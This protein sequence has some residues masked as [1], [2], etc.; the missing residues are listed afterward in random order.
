M[1]TVIYLVKFFTIEGGIHMKK[2][3][4]SVLLAALTVCTMVPLSAVQAFAA[5]T[6]FA[7]GDDEEVI[8]EPENPSDNPELILGETNNIVFKNGNYN[9]EYLIKPTV[10]AAYKLYSDAEVSFGGDLYYNST[11][12]WISSKGYDYSHNFSRSYLFEAGR[13]Y[14]LNLYYYNGFPDDGSDIEFE[15]NTELIPFADTLSISNGDSYEGYRGESFYIDYELSP[16]TAFQEDVQFKSSNEDAVW[17]NSNG[18]VELNAPGTAVITASTV[19]GLSETITVTVLEETVINVGETK[20]VSLSGG[21][22][23][24]F[25]FTA[26]ET[27]S[28]AFYSTGD[29]D[30]YGQIYDSLVSGLASDD[31]SGENG[32][33]R[34]V[35]KMSQG[36]TYY[37]DA[38]LYYSSDSGEFDVAVEA[39][40][41][42]E[43]L[44]INNG[45]KLTKYITDSF[46]LN[47]SLLPEGSSE[48]NITYS[49]D[50]SD[51]VS[52][53]DYNSYARCR[54]AGTATIT[55]TSER[56]LT[57]T[58]EVTVK[59]FEPLTLDTPATANIT[60]E[61]DHVMFKFT[62]PEEGYYDIKSTGAQDETYAR[63]GE[64]SYDSFYS[65]TS[66]YGG[67]DNNFSIRYHL[68]QNREYILSA[69]L[70][71][72]SVTGSF[73]V[74]LSKVPNAEAIAIDLGSEISETK[75]NSFNLKVVYTPENALE[76]NITWESSDESVV[77]VSYSGRIELLKEGDA[78]VTATTESGLSASI[79][80]HVTGYESIS[81]GET[82]TI[83]IENSGNAA[84][85]KF[86][87]DETCYYSVY[88]TS[89]S[90]TVGEILD[91]NM[92]SVYYNDDGGEGRN[93]LICEQLEEGKT[94][95]IKAGFYSSSTGEF[96]LSVVKHPNATAISFEQSAIEG[97][98]NEN[99]QL[100][101]LVEPEDGYYGNLTWSTSDE[102][103]ASVYGGSVYFNKVGTAEITAETDSG[104]KATCSV[105]VLDYESIELDE[106]KQV[107]VNNGSSVMYKFV[108]EETADYNFYSTGDY[109]TRGWIY[110]SYMN[111]LT[112]SAWGGEGNNFKLN[113]HLTAG[114]TY[115][116]KTSLDYSDDNA[117]Y[118]VTVEMAPLAT[119]MSV[120]KGNF[121]A[122]P[123]GSGYLNIQ[124][125][126][127]DASSESVTWSSSDDEIV[128]VNSNGGMT[129]NSV[130]TAVITATSERGLTD[131][132]TITVTEPVEINAGDTK[133]V[134]VENPDDRVIFKF[135]P[136]Q[137]GE[138]AFYSEGNTRN[139]R[140]RVFDSDYYYNYSQSGDRINMQRS[141]NE[142]ETYYFECGFTNEE[143]TGSYDVTLTYCPPAEEVVINAGKA[144]EGYPGTS[145]SPVV[146]FL[147]EHSVREAYELSSADTEIA[148]VN[149]YG[150][151]FLNSVGTT[152]ITL[153]SENGLTATVEVTVKDYDPLAIGETKTAVVE[154]SSGHMFK[155]IP[156]K[157]GY[158]AFWSTSNEDTYGTLYDSE[159][160]EINEDDDGGENN[161]F[162]VKAM[163]EGG[164]TYY[165]RARYLSSTRTGSFAVTSAEV[166]YITSLTLVSP[167]DQTTYV[168]G[169]TSGFDYTGLKLQAVWSDGEVVN[170]EYGDGRIRDEY[171]SYFFD[172]G[173]ETVTALCGGQSV[174]FDVSV[175][176][177][178]VESIEI[179]KGIEE[180]LIEGV[181][182]HTTT[183]Y[184]PETGKNDLEFFEY[185]LPDTSDVEVKVNYT[186]GTSGIIK[187]GESLYGCKLIF[188]DDQ[189]SKPWT[190]GSDNEIT[191]NLLGA[192]A[193]LYVTVAE[194]PVDYIE[195]IDDGDIEVVENGKGNWDT[196]YNRETGEDEEFFRYDLSLGS[197]EV[198]IHFKDGTLENAEPGDRINGYSV[199][200]S[201][202][203]YNKPFKL[204]SDN[205]V[206]VYYMGNFVEVPITVVENPVE[207]VELVSNST[208]KLIENGDGRWETRYDSALGSD[209]DFFYYNLY[210]LN[211]A[212]VRI[213][214]KDGTSE[215]AEQGEYVRGYYV[216][217]NGNQYS[218][219][220]TL[221]NNTYKIS[222]LGVE[223]DAI[224][225]VVQNPVKSIQLL[226]GFKFYRTEDV[227]GYRTNRYDD[228]LGISVDF[229]Y[230]YTSGIDKAEI[231]INYKDGT[232]EIA[233][234]YDYID[235]KQVEVSYN[236]YDKPWTT[237][238][239]NYITV[240]YLG[241]ETMIPVIINKNPV[242]GIEVIKASDT[243]LIENS[244]G[245]W[246]TRYNPET[247]EYDIEYFQYYTDDLRDAAIRINYTDGTQKTAYIGES[248]D[249]YYIG[250]ESEQYNTP[251]TVGS[252]NIVYITYMGK[253]T[254]MNVTVV[255][256][257]VKSI[258]I[259]SAPTR[260]YIYGDS[261]YG[262]A[263]YFYPSDLT[264]LKFTVTYK[265]GSKKTYTDND[266]SEGKIDGGR[267][268]IS[269]DNVQKVGTMVAT[270]TY[271]GFN[272][273]YNIT[274]KD[275][276]VGSVEFVKLPTN[277]YLS[278]YYRVDWRGSEIKVNYTN[279]TS[280]TLT[281]DDSNLI[282]GFGN[283]TGFFVGFELD[284]ATGVLTS[285]REDENLYRA[286]VNY[287]GK[288]G[289]KNGL[290]YR[291]DK[292]VADVQIEN[293][294]YE[295]DGM[296]LKVT[297]EDG[298]K[299]NITLDN[300]VDNR[301]YWNPDVNYVRALTD[302][303]MLNFEIANPEYRDALEYDV[304]VFNKPVSLDKEYI[305]GDADGNG[306]VDV[307]DATLIQ[308]YIAQFRVSNTSQILSCGDVNGDGIISV[309]DVTW[310]QRYVAGMTVPYAIGEK[311]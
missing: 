266:I 119:A 245:Y 295:A 251:W 282:Y 265:D 182:G 104:L 64:Y 309:S 168:E 155:I 249:G 21:K 32:N 136:A 28:Y 10:T 206:K 293:F 61:L 78:E 42:A 12:D 129:F 306:V 177:N 33:F 201:E 3:L 7:L 209:V 288:T 49:T 17:V 283:Q 214:F 122:V 102:D 87:P 304:Y 143:T 125:Y 287:A 165:L 15:M 164:K 292:T 217:A 276:G 13:E 91:E 107:E 247:G 218:E 30:T 158:Y 196:Y 57:D 223:V 138:Y 47:S 221:G 11:G 124:F 180:P 84:Y 63:L 140:L 279:G 228:V 118:S 82:K 227:D 237:D 169:F 52:I 76:E 254:E 205:Y 31:S 148:E 114:E 220:F 167:P 79:L 199:Y 311:I 275:S 111:Q 37:L 233:H 135:T 147:P 4:L 178:P 66:A 150:T 213:N 183:R 22:S 197:V 307:N 62:V 187:A 274:V 171:V 131:S 272:A 258:T 262:G 48:E 257:P 291:E 44:V 127:G 154:S 192:E 75:N 92:N 88:T 141:L 302:K 281:L 162:R 263:N 5:Q 252:D 222:Y 74:V 59:D 23:A 264:G 58:L 186:D 19:S 212:V 310:I 238:G 45:D 86:V 207:S 112:S 24:R 248:V 173:E 301:I 139:C 152:T 259:D 234:P 16:E 43:Q 166:P 204:G 305:L 159:M 116:F 230:Y 18:R 142:G 40:P 175:I 83:N 51:V 132:K 134:T 1:I 226:G 273:D 188:S 145:L 68:Y 137:D 60:S 105:T 242:A 146:T 174:S 215:I 208:A 97:Y 255:E 99:K 133:T 299:E 194:N 269:C 236:Q 216:E 270:L 56:G 240:S 235:D 14:R 20:T 117:E 184:N 123:G 246:N 294:S 289:Q 243:Q 308:R 100:T 163:L 202:D 219:P 85:Y 300:V 106:V 29:Y 113:Y 50:N 38:K 144:I 156:E 67:D 290:I 224:A 181:N 189:Y 267:F 77:S 280:K 185:E 46:N 176:E 35:Y 296:I 200:W 65:Y 121:I 94:Y 191:V 286:T 90:D 157:D 285:S 72:S 53:D 250:T 73:N 128:S 298:S 36:A 151:I 271:K 25:A 81:A 108:P 160:G 120:Y 210:R 256:T 161:N 172:S 239:E 70:N 39:L 284:G 69:A 9:A 268:V 109:N 203:Q 26:P 195:L 261:L 89:D 277:V 96:D 149:S 231:Q 8:V 170:W 241:A 278:K 232:S 98:P 93:F 41:F 225:T 71:N 190:V 211:D 27:R 198:A 303:G 55:A 95:Y 179:I 34:V 80:V 193:P 260:Q 115:Y 153:T 103:I 2:R 244:D 110:D 101:V 229:F 297:Y 54:S 130:G 253:R 126:P 6:D